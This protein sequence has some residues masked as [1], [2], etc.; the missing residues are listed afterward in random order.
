MRHLT[1][2]HPERVAF[3]ELQAELDGLI[4]AECPLT[5]SIMVESIDRGFDNSEEMD[6]MSY[7]ASIDGRVGTDAS[8]A[9]AT[10]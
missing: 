6:D 8:S 3:E 10:V 7:R 2:F 5:G 4:A 1:I 9:T